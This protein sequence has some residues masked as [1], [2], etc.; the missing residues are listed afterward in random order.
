M[1]TKSLFAI[2]LAATALA[3]S[4]KKTAPETTQEIS[5]RLAHS[6]VSVTT[7]TDKVT[8]LSSFGVT[9]TTGASGAEVPAWENVTFSGWEIFTG[10][11]WW[12]ETDPGFRFYAANSAISV[13]RGEAVLQARNTSD[14]VAAYLPNPAYKTVNNIKAP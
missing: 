5:F 2:A 7:K 14:V 13:V 9:A 11:K 10:G 3:V 4:C 1:R 8:S 6:P 12:P